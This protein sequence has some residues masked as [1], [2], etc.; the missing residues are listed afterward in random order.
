MV[1]VAE[2]RLVQ[3]LALDIPLAL[4]LALEI[5][6]EVF[7]TRRRQTSL[8]IFHLLRISTR[9]LPKDQFSFCYDD[10]LQT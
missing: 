6:V 7:A 4:P 3:L 8:L 2:L 10:Y 9:I 1:G 5:P